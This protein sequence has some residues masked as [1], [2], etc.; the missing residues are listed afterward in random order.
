MQSLICDW[1]N[2]KHGETDF[3]DNM[4]EQS[5]IQVQVCSWRSSVNFDEFQYYI[6]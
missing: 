2:N 1:N 4:S 5:A 6:K 3:T